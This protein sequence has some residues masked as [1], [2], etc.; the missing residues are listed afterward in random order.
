M[1]FGFILYV[2][3]MG[4]SNYV[5]S[6]NP[7]FP[8]FGGV[9]T[10]ILF[11]FVAYA[12]NLPIE[13]ITSSPLAKKRLRELSNLYLQFLN[14]FQA[15]TP[16]KE[17]GGSSFRFAEYIEAMGL[18]DVVVS[19]SG[20]LTFN[21]DELSDENIK[22]IP[23]N[24]LKI[25]KEHSWVVETINDFMP[26][27]VRTYEILQLQSKGEASEWLEQIFQRHG[28]FLA[29]QGGL[30]AM[31][32]EV[33]IPEI[34][35]ELQLGR[36]YLFKEEKPA[37][38]YKKLREALS[39]GFASLCISKLDPQKVRERYGVGKAS[40]FWLTFKK[41]EGTINPKDFVKLNRTISEFV[42]KPDA[43]IVL[44]DCFDQIK[45]A[46]GLQKSLTVLKDFRNLCNETSS[47]ILISINPELFEKQQLAAIEKELEEVK[48]E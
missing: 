31:P 15:K 43:S 35:K 44:L 21:P 45:F 14:A 18:K 20:R 11:L 32:K 8:P 40:M 17:L 28:G 33:K 2:I 10:I 38:A 29:K 30:A 41:T 47:I 24:I 19:G 23:D 9:I 6:S 48:I 34:F 7:D 26:V 37:R 3:S 16:G 46:N 13:K 25:M 42:K 27:L 22:E 12:I 1:L 5:I 4:A 39:Y 36:A